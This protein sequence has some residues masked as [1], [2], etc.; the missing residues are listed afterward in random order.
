MIEIRNQRELDRALATTGNGRDELI[1]CFGSA[2]YTLWGNATATLWENATATLRGNAT[3][4]LR[5]NA[6]ATLWENATATLWENATA[7]LRGNA[8]ATLWGNATARAFGSGTIEAGRNAVVL[9]HDSQSQITGGRILEMAR[10]KT[11]AEWCE[12]YGVEVV[13]GN[14]ILFKSLYEDFTSGHFTPAGQRVSYAP[15]STPEAPDWDGGENECGGGL[16]FSPH[17]V[18]ADD[19]G[20]EEKHAACPVP[21]AEIVVHPD[22]SMP[23]KVKARRVVEPGCWEVDIDG[24]RVG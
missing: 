1:A 14:A 9:D 15:G 18:M 10:P 8:T 23:Q 20:A 5:E 6:T 7:T 22:G 21:L 17:P 24:K 3:A 16:H 13:N 12:H 4:T 2:E 11:P 19:F